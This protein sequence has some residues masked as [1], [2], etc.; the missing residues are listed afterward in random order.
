MQNRM[1]IVC[2]RFNKEKELLFAEK[3]AN[4]KYLSKLGLSTSKDPP[5]GF[6]E[7]TSRISFAEE[8]AFFEALHYIRYC[9]SCSGK[10]SKGLKSARMIRL[11]KIHDIIRNRIIA[12][13]LGLVHRAAAK[14]SIYLEYDS[15]ISAG[16]LGL[17]DATECYDP[18]KG[19]RFSTYATIAI[20]RRF[21]REAKIRSKI[22]ISEEIEPDSLLENSGIDKNTLFY[23][24]RLNK[25]IEDRAEDLTED[26]INILQMRFGTKVNPDGMTLRQIAE[27]KNLSPERIRQL[28]NLALDKLRQAFSDTDILKE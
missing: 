10:T 3:Q 16:C 18:W 4:H 20:I 8:I 17:V 12:A 23:L 21:S 24:D 13:N 27:I 2:K 5:C 15:K 14:T 26:D 11:F 6:K 28:Q 22:D 1:E 9:M 19:F 7:S 25:I